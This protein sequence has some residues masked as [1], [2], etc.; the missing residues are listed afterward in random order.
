MNQRRTWYAIV[1][2][3]ILVSSSI[4]LYQNRNRLDF[5]RGSASIQGDLNGSGK[6][7]IFDYNIL[8]TNFGKSGVG[9]I[10]GSGKVDIFDYN[11]LVGQFG[12]V[13]TSP[14]PTSTPTKICGTINTSNAQRELGFNYIV[15]FVAGGDTPAAPSQS[16]ILIFENELPLGPA[17]SQHA[18][19]RNPG[20]GR[21]SHWGDSLYFSASDNTSPVTNGK[22]YTYGVPQ[23]AVCPLKNI[24]LTK[25]ASNTPGYATFQSHDPHVVANSKGIFVVFLKHEEAG[26]LEAAYGNMH[27]YALMRST[28]GGKTFSELYVSPLRY[29]KAPTI[30]TDEFDTIYLFGA[31]YSPAGTNP[32]SGSLLLQ[33]FSA[34]NNYVNPVLVT[35]PGEAAGKSTALFDQVRKQFYYIGFN[36]TPFLVLDRAGAIL[37][38]YQLFKTGTVAHVQYPHL[39]MDGS[40]LYV[41][42]TTSKPTGLYNGIHFIYSDDGGATWFAPGVS[43]ALTLPIIS[44]DTGPTPEIVSAAHLNTKSTWLANFTVLNGIAHFTYIAGFTEVR[45]I[46]QRFLVEPFTKL[47]EIDG[48]WG[49]QNGSLYSFDGFFTK[50]GSTLYVVGGAG[51]EQTMEGKRPIIALKSTDNGATWSV[52]AR[53]T[54]LVFPYSIGGARYIRN[55]GITGILT[56]YVVYPGA[57]NDKEVY[58]VHL[59]LP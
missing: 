41:A 24:G 4:Y 3:C 55:F 33:I 43:G 7:D 18:D 8:V 48:L 28:D 13:A 58:F 30:E 49:D 14:S 19:I 5:S 35:I 46:Y 22:A 54:Q 51:A 57:Q 27:Q 50:D 34:D 1:G 32:S 52:V 47:T 42:W 36:D 26:N 9:D 15:P 20:N 25:I 29:G 17:H 44:D 6:V 38:Q 56:H 23:G 40:R 10:N 16:N 59:P 2:I 21:F 39:A 53:S 45:Q 31:D 37:R 11:I 12:A